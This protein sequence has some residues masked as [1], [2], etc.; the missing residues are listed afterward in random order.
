MLLRVALTLA[1]LVH[2]YPAWV[3]VAACRIR[4]EVSSFDTCL[5]LCAPQQAVAIGACAGGASACGGC[6]G[7]TCL[8]EESSSDDPEKAPG[9]CPLCHFC[10]CS[11]AP[12]ERFPPI[13]RQGTEPKPI[14]TAVPIRFAEFQPEH[15]ITRVLRVAPCVHAAWIPSRS[16][17]CVWTI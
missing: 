11:F 6:C 5:V 9:G 1:I 3:C 13:D 16:V 2:A 12:P 8:S 7:D 14:E 15:R 10:Q 4:A 17:L